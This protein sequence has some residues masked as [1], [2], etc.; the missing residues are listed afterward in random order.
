MS[1]RRVFQ[2]PPASGTA[3]ISRALCQQP[4]G[5]W[6]NWPKQTGI[7]HIVEDASINKKYAQLCAPQQAAV[8][9][10]RDDFMP[11]P[12]SEFNFRLDGEIV[13]VGIDKRGNPKWVTA[14][15]AWRESCDKHVYTRIAFT[16]KPV[17]ED[18]MNLFRGYGVEAKH[19]DCH[20][21]LQHIREVICS[22]NI[23]IYNAMLNLIGWQ[24]QNIGKP[25]RIIVMLVSVNQQQVGKGVLL[26]H[27]LL[28]I[29][30]SCSWTDERA[31]KRYYWNFQRHLT[32]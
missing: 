14:A 19:G 8:I 17:K 16:N 5:Y 24:L 29:F 25:S 31:N 20:L 18:T 3:S 27:I 23:E 10:L 32:R 30:G 13:C 7:P 6:K 15:K 12:L 2:Q 22:K 9:I 11:I 26:E 28:P 4:V 21:I 1:I